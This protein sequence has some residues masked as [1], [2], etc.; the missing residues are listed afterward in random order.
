MYAAHYHLK[1]QKKKKKRRRRKEEEGEE[2]SISPQQISL[3]PSACHTHISIYWLTSLA[4]AINDLQ[5][6][7]SIPSIIGALRPPHQVF[8]NHFN[9][10]L[11]ISILCCVRIWLHSFRKIET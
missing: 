10:Y 6:T 1:N 7:S 9:N 4:L 2:D 5:A 3:A 11:C 8:M